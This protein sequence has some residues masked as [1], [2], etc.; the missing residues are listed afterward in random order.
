MGDH[1]R[2]QRSYINIK[3]TSLKLFTTTALEKLI[4]GTTD[5]GVQNVLLKIH[6]TLQTIFPAIPS[7][8]ILSSIMLGG[9]RDTYYW[10]TNE[11][12]YSRK[13]QIKPY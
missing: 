4:K 8:A 12:K 1:E 3:D 11:R 9:G 2:R 7:D 10:S 5:K 6:M 13:Q